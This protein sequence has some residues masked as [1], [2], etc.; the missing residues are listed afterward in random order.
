MSLE[1]ETRACLRLWNTVICTAINDSIRPFSLVF[2][3]G[4][5][6]KKSF[7]R[8]YKIL[9]KRQENPFIFHWRD[10]GGEPV[11]L[12]QSRARTWFESYGEDFINVCHYAGIEDP[13]SLSKRVM[14]MCALADEYKEKYKIDKSKKETP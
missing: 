3:T 6:Y 12:N 11:S 7:A 10:V 1:I 4:E 9:L 13:A 5:N 8:Q 2:Y 14:E